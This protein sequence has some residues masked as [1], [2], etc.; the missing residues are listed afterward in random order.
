[1]FKKFIIAYDHNAKPQTIKRIKETLA[2]YGIE[3]VSVDDSKQDNDY[4]ILAQ[5]AYKLY[6]S[7]N[8]DGL[9]LLCGTGVGMNMVANRFSGIR[10][11]LADS[12]ARAYFSKRHENANCL[13]LSTSYSDE[14]YEIKFC[15]RKMV[16]IIRVFVSTEFQ[17]E[18][19]HKRRIGEIEELDRRKV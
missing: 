9:L 5:E 8:A 3:S 12:E 6:K 18:E 17:G 19:R 16:R 1:M 13:V 11:V 10:S 14:K 15:G 7:E 2:E 4:P